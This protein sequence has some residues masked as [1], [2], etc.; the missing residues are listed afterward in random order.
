MKR[1]YRIYSDLRT[2]SSNAT[3]KLHV[4]MIIYV[5]KRVMPFTNLG[6]NGNSFGMNCAQIGILEQSNQ[7][8]FACL[9]TKINV[10]EK[11]KL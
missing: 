5:S 8:C 10:M 1:V 4:L 11:E 2:L 9:R 6:H 7:V 3:C